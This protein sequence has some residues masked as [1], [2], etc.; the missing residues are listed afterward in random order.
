MASVC[1]ADMV[2][3]LA[4]FL[5]IRTCA[6]SLRLSVRPNCHSGAHQF[7]TW[8]LFG[9]HAQDD[10]LEIIQ[11]RNLLDHWASFIYFLKRIAGVLR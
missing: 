11:F 3:V 6:V 8:V 7:E 2:V 9:E 1:D 5:P 10:F 4:W